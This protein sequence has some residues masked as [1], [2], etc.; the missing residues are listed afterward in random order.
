MGWF[1]GFEM[2]AKT[3]FGRI[4]YFGL[5][6]AFGALVSSMII[7]SLSPEMMSTLPVRGSVIVYGGLFLGGIALLLTRLFGTVERD[8]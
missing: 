4:I 1:Y 2:E 6:L 3:T 7:V 5:T 8:H